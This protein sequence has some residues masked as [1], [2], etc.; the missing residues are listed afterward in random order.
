M[1][2]GSPTAKP[3]ESGKKPTSKWAEPLGELAFIAVLIPV[4]YYL[5][6]NLGQQ[7]IRYVSI[8]TLLIFGRAM[9]ALWAAIFSK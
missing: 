3:I 9:K 6:D 5:S 4:F 8:L 2:E 7:G 1:A